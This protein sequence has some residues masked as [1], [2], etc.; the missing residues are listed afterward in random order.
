MFPP[1][2]WWLVGGVVTYWLNVNSQKQS[3]LQ[4][5]DVGL[6]MVRSATAVSASTA[7]G[8]IIITSTVGALKSESTA[9]QAAQD[10]AAKLSLS[11]LAPDWL[12]L[13]TSVESAGYPVLANSIATLGM[14][15]LETGQLNIS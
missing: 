1:W 11:V 12:V 5:V 9:S 6:L 7:T 10:A 2:L 4:S 8:T 3:A 15:L 13:A 14:T